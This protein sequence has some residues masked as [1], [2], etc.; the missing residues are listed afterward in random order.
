MFFINFLR[1]LFGKRPNDS[2]PK[3]AI[4]TDND[5]SFRPGGGQP[6]KGFQQV[7][8]ARNVYRG[9]GDMGITADQ[10]HKRTPWLKIVGW[11]V[12]LATS[13]LA[14]Y[15]LYVLKWN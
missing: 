13:V 14:G 12:G 6:I 4:I 11:A 3:S 5:I 7:V 1:W 9:A 8:Q 15:I 2:S 10:E